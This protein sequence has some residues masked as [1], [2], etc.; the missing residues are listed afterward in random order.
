GR[1]RFASQSYALKGTHGGCV[2]WQCA[3][4]ATSVASSY[5]SWWRAGRRRP[6][7]GPTAPRTVCAPDLEADGQALRGEVAAQAQRGS[8]GQT[9]RGGQPRP[10]AVTALLGVDDRSRLDLRGGAPHGRHDQH[11]AL[12]VPGEVVHLHDCIPEEG[13]QV[14]VERKLDLEVAIGDTA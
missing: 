1:H 5:A 2:G 8:A 7:S 6:R 3:L 9:E 11:R 13:Q 4:P 12:L 10:I 14:V